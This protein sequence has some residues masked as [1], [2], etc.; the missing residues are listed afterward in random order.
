GGGGLVHGFMDG[1]ERMPTKGGG[2]LEQLQQ[3]MREY[4]TGKIA[5]VSG[6]YYAMD[7]DRRWERIAKA[8]SA[9]VFG[10]AEGGKF[11]DAVQGVKE[12][13]NKGVTDEFIVPVVCTDAKGQALTTIRAE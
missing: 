5:S 12:S 3:A 2:F 13:Y 8:Y 9:M 4:N 11:T 10:E 1:G 6:R 7:R